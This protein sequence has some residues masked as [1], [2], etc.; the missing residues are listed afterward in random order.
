MRPLTAFEALT[1]AFTRTR[2]FLF[3]PFRIGRS[4]KLATTGYLT[5]GGVFY[6]PFPL[7]YLPALAFVPLSSGARFAISA[8]ALLATA[9]FTFLFHLCSRLSFAF[10]DLVLNRGEFV[11]PA[12]RPYGPA[13]RRWSIAKV[14]FGSAATLCLAVPLADYARKLIPYF[15]TQMAHPNQP[16]DP[17]FLIPLFTGYFV[18]V[19]GL[20]S[21]YFVAALANDFVVPS[22]ALEGTTVREAFRRFGLLLRYEPGEVLLYAALKGTAQFAGSM[23][24]NLAF[25]LAFFIMVLVLALVGGLLGY[26]LHKLGI[27]LSVLWGVAGVLGIPCMLLLAVYGVCLGLGTVAAFLQAYLLYFLGGRYPAL[28][29]LLEPPPPQTYAR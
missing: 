28:G 14:L 16:L 2:V 4:W 9:L 11:A 3:S 20:L 1:P 29:A 17:Q 19:F 23:A 7:L 21:S 24:V 26:G 8:A 15:K 13:S 18:L 27:P 10:F 5:L 6:L 25:E 22:L 12:W